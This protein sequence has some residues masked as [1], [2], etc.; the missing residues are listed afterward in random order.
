GFPPGL[1]EKVLKGEPPLTARPGS[2]L[3]PA[4]LVATASL[5]ADKT[6]RHVHQNELASYLMYPKVFLE[7]AKHRA[8]FG[9]V[10]ALP[11]PVF[12]YGMEPGQEI[13]VDLEKGKS[14]IIR[15]LATSDADAEG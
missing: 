12:F 8:A 1:A 15:Y 9:D 7:F 14:L 11:T 10:A 3:P 6:G 4:D 5:L 2:T 13:T